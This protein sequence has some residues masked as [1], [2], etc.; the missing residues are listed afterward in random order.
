V[1]PSLLTVLLAITLVACAHQRVPAKP[2]A[3]HWQFSVQGQLAESDIAAIVAIV[4]RIPDLDH[5]IVRIVAKTPKNAFV[6]TG[7]QRGPL[8][9]GGH[10]VTLEKR[11]GRWVVIE[12]WR[13][14]IWAS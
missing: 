6:H 4:Q 3:S 5:K 12:D 7:E 11:N 8:D 10:V 9:G 1:K 2:A 13:E 14:S